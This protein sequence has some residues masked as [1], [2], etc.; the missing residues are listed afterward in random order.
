MA[1]VLASWMGVACAGHSAPD[2]FLPNKVEAQNQAFGGWV[3]LTFLSEQADRNLAG[4]LIAVT[5]DS[6]WVM[7]GSMVV[8]VP[9]TSVA[10]GE[11]AGYDSES[12][13]V[14]GAVALGVISTI[15]NGFFLVFTAPM[16]LIGGSMAAN[17]QGK[18]GL[19]DLPPMRWADLAKF[20]RFPQ[21]I[22]A[23]LDLRHLR[24]RTR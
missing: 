4:E 21:G 6:L 24:P 15:S 1:L 22:P 7:D 2:G 23:S 14:G 13:Q 5:E 16:W 9:V 19:D 8:A 11:L 18:V 3:D 12:G 17:S 20:A 10:S